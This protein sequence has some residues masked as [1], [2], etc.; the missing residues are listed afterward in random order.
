MTPCQPEP[1]YQK[2]P[3]Q[4]G[5]SYYFLLEKSLKTGFKNL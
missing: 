2:S 3:E 4:T 1:E 5:G